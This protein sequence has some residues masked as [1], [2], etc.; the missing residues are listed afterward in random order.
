MKNVKSA[1]MFGNA[2]PIPRPLAP[3]LLLE[4][5]RKTLVRGRASIS[6][7][8]SSLKKLA[9]QTSWAIIIVWR[10]GLTA[11][12]CG[13]FQVLAHNSRIC[14]QPSC[15]IACLA[16]QE[17]INVSAQLPYLA[18]TTAFSQ[19]KV[20]L[21]SFLQDFFQQKQRHRPVCVHIHS[22]I[23][24]KRGSKCYQNTRNSFVSLRFLITVL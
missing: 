21:P 2:S 4:I 13:H 22:T 18:D 12:V 11:R 9:I 1:K 5:P 10:P 6:P 24:T 3:Q 17:H 14:F 8:G 20:F 15:S 16:D 7:S 23:L 19:T